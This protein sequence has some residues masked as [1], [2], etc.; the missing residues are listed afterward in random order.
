MTGVPE[1][2]QD[3]AGTSTELTSSVVIFL[4]LVF[5][6]LYEVSLGYVKDTL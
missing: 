5:K 2:K 3:E 4:R 1:N 6:C